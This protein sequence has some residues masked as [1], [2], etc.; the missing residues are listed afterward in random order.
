VL[1]K[2]QKRQQRQG[3]VVNAVLQN[4]LIQLAVDDTLRE[5]FNKAT[6]PQQDAILANEFRVGLK[7]RQAVLSG[8]PGRVRA[9]LR[10]SDQ[11]GN[12]SMAL[13]KAAAKRAAGRKK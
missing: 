4:F 7:S 9:R 13:A 2:K 10:F 12:R 5:R 11:N 3:G 8:K 1:A 6:D